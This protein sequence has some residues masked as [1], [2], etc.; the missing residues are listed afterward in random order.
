MRKVKKPELHIYLIGG[1]D[2]ESI[3]NGKYIL[4]GGAPFHKVMWVEGKAYQVINRY[5]KYV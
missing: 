4:D 3:S 2:V 5:I 1:T